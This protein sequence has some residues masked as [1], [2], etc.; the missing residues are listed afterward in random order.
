MAAPFHL[1]GYGCGKPWVAWAGSKLKGHA[2]C[3]FSPEEG[4]ALLARYE[5]DPRLTV[6][7]L[8]RE[9]GET[10]SVVEST[11]YWA[12]QRRRVVNS[13]TVHE[14]PTEAGA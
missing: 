9:I 13:N 12:K 6:A 4:D 5:A 11:L 8:A 14:G 1:C 10:R 2:R 7:R 3:R